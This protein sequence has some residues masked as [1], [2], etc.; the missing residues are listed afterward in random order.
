MDDHFLQ[1]IDTVILRVS[2][3]DRAKSWY[4]EKLGF[5]NIHEDIKLRLVV[6]DTFNRQL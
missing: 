5:K 2:D 4:V 1:G 3:I 6:L